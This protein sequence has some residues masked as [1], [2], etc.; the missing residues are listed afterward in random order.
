MLQCL[1]EIII[2][3]GSK[4]KLDFR[5]VEIRVEGI[6]VVLQCLTETLSCCGAEGACAEELLGSICGSAVSHSKTQSE[7]SWTP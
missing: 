3:K 2:F 1:T 5:R 7:K 4:V 6:A